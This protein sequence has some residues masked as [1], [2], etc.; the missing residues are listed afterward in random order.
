M[1]MITTKRGDDGRSDYFG[2]RVSKS[3]KVLEAVGTLDELQSI[4]D[5]ESIQKDLSS[6]MVA[7]SLNNKV[8][9]LDEKILN[10]KKEFGTLTKFLIFK[11]E[12]ARKLN[13]VRT[14]CRR[15]ERR[16][17]ALNKIKQIDPNILIYINRLSDYLFKLSQKEEE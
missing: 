12:K 9:G 5:D 17:V 1:L 13:W 8:I 16:L 4:V 14:V 7:I 10:L 11:N 15:A 3:G 6:I 2:K